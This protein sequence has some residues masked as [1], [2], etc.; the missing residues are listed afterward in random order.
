M[1]LKFP[2]LDTLQLALTSGVIPPNVA[3][4]GA[5]AGFGEE[6]QL[7]VEP[8]VNLPKAAQNALRS[9][10][11]Q[12]CK[13]SGA[14][15]STEVSSWLELLPLVRDPDAL[16]DLSQTPVL[17][18]LASGEELSRLV[19]EIMRLGN[20]RQSFRWLE[21][22]GSD[23]EGRALL[24]VI[25]PPYYSLLRALD[26]QDEDDAPRGFIEQA[27][28]VWVELGF[29]HP[30][31]ERIKPAK[32]QM[33]LLRP[34]RQWMLIPDGELRDIYEVLELQ[35]PAGKTEW[36]DSK[37]AERI[38]VPLALR[39][40]GSPDGAEL[41][42]LRDDAVSV[43]NHF[44]QHSDDRTIE[45][46]RFAV[47][48]RGEQSIVVL[49]VRK[50]QQPPP[51]LV[52]PAQGYKPHLKLPNLFLPAG[53]ILYPPVRRDIV[54]KLLAEDVNRLVW[55]Q[56]GG[57][58]SFLP[59]SLPEDSFRPLKE[60]V[61]YVL[62]SEH[63]ALEAWMQAS[64]F[65]FEHFV[66]DEEA[67]SKPK[68]PPSE[69]SQK[70]SHQPRSTGPAIDAPDL[71]FVEEVEDAAE[72]EAA[73]DEFASVAK[74]E[75][76]ELQKRLA[77]LENEFLAFEGGLDTPERQ[78]LWPQLASLNG[79]LEKKTE[80]AA[81]CW[82]NALWERNPPP[83]DWITAWLR[84]ERIGLM[85]R[86]ETGHHGPPPWIGGTN[87]PAPQQEITRQDLDRLLR[88]QEPTSSDLRTLT[89]YIVWAARRMP[90]PEA[91]VGKLAEVQR[92]LETHERLLPV[93]AVWLAWYHLAQLA[94]G[95]ALALAR[96]RDRLLERL[97]QAGL[98]PEQDLPSF[99]R[100]AGQATSQ[101]FRAVREWM[102]ELAELAHKWVQDM[103]DTT[104]LVVPVKPPIDA[105]SA[106]VN[107]LFSFGLARLGESDAARALLDRAT[108]ILTGRDDGHTFLLRAFEYRIRRVLDGQ[109]GGGPLP[110]ALVG[111]L[112]QME[113]KH[114]YVV[115][116][117]RKN[118]QIL[119][120]EQRVDPYRPWLAKV[121]ELDGELSSLNDI[122]DRQE[123]VQRI[124]RLL[125]DTPRNEAGIERRVRIVLA[126]LEAAP[127]VHEAF[128]REMLDAALPAYDAQ[129]ALTTLAD[130]RRLAA[131]QQHA[132]FLE[133]ALFVAAHFDRIEHIHPLVARFEKLLQTQRGPQAIHDIDTL[134][135]QCFRGLRKLGMRNEI[136]HLLEVMADLVL[137]G[138]SMP[139]VEPE[140]LRALLHVASGWY[141]FGRDSQA[142]PILQR[143][144][145]VLL[146]G[147]LPP[148]EQLALACAY[149]R[150]VGQAAVSVAQK[151]LEEIFRS[152]RGIRDGFLTNTHFSA[153]Q[154]DL[155]EAVVLAV[156]SDDFTMGTQGRRW[157][158]D[159][160]LL[161]R[162]RIHRDWR[163][164]ESHG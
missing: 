32:G 43:V 59:E 56:P 17:F 153:S 39:A 16:T 98:R 19:I 68:K 140:G 121:S 67:P 42:V 27:A 85:Q 71:P 2:N 47:G 63:E 106:Y 114:R 5:V 64:R 151:R 73:L 134:A 45:Q 18:D 44:V 1:I 109:S 144:R 95:D 29:R 82:L 99:L 128:A 21:E 133:R 13:A 8:A 7:W 48:Q 62:D 105:M 3:A 80:D 51:V 96:T 60:W 69:R 94:H 72:E 49:R 52:L 83:A 148:R 91:L 74:V 89:A 38:R 158:D 116:R 26:H 92:Y 161:V 164:L 113:T 117:L 46:L 33:L 145:E 65:D 75:P 11:G 146:K 87:T 14:V 141:Y 101:R 118:S 122:S 54:R 123:I 135:G 15:L 160:E 22:K 6:D 84:T 81:L 70:G 58:G 77:E 79:Q 120:P 157:L 112:D 40:G 119:E 108:T 132:R 28:G 110:A 24:R 97:Y 30:L 20:D 152:L 142:D 125:K 115:D 137:H 102:V 107:L 50:Q 61:D 66:C 103:S 36:K 126:G 57:E 143:V 138:R 100:F 55:L 111:E 76:S 130:D 149:A 147:D 86:H 31:A 53:T 90:P 156:V 37:L 9:L 136:D 155:I 159:D 25:G 127:R 78:A 163:A 104:N 4:A 139:D 41:W 129:P 88:R 12:V 35:L 131:L 10:G 93:R 150:A 124:A 34:P 162:R 23:Q 154:L